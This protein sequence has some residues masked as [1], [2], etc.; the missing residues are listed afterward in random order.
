MDKQTQKNLINLVNKNYEEIAEHYSETRKKHMSPLWDEL[1]KITKKVK[2]EDKVLDVGCGNGRLLTAF[3]KKD[4]DYLGIDPSEA[5]L[6]EAK[7][8]NPSKNFVVG[9]ILELSKL[10]EINFDYVFSIAVLH[11]LPGQDLRVMA[12]KQ[13]KNKIADD[14]EIIISVWNLW[15]Q[16]KFR[17]LI[18]KFF[19][20][21]LLKKNKM[22]FGDIL[23]DW[24]NP[25]GEIAS[26]RYYHAFTK[27]SL[28]KIAR[29]A[30]LKIIGF[31]KD[32]Y[33]YYLTLK[34]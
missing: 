31:K 14:G 30:G 5:L 20:L 33:N 4:I 21:K 9:D 12:M 7:K 24:K 29:K 19:I 34:K 27:R 2:K 6:K 11:H 32:K 15:G 1:L 28:K 13:L 25:R 26:K 23:F 10:P 18:W 16:K 22:D 8:I 3:S 17:K